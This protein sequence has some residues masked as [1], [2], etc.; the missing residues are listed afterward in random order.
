MNVDDNINVDRMD[1]NAQEESSLRRCGHT[2]AYVSPSIE[3]IQKRSS[4]EFTGEDLACLD[5]KLFLNTPKAAA[6]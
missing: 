4:G 5:L 6:P 2:I 3:N 1:R